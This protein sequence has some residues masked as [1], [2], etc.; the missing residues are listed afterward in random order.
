MGLA[1][2]KSPVGVLWPTVSQGGGKPDNAFSPLH[3][4]RRVWTLF[5]WAASAVVIG[6][7]GFG[8]AV[9]EDVRLSAW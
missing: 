7:S 5:A 8:A 9:A 3:W 4:A 2:G 1:R 6:Q